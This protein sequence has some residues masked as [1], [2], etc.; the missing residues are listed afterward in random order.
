MLLLKKLIDTSCKLDCS[1]IVEGDYKL[2]VA[3]ASRNTGI[4]Y[5][6][7]KT[8]RTS[9]VEPIDGCLSAF[10]SCKVCTDISVL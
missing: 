9:F 10:D 4:A 2:I 8:F 7:V 1:E 3:T 5:D 6:S